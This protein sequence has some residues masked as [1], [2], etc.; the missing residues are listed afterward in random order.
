M[1]LT[2]LRVGH[3]L[4]QSQ[5]ILQ[6]TAADSPGDSRAFPNADGL[7]VTRDVQTTKREANHVANGDSPTERV[8]PTLALERGASHRSASS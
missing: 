1:Q 7:P 4:R 5:R 8:G 3:S 6:T 2:P